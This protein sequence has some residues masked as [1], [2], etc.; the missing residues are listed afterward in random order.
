MSLV[1]YIILIISLFPNY[2]NGFYIMSYITLII[3]YIPELQE[4][5]LHIL[6]YHIDQKSVA[7]RFFE[8][9]PGGVGIQAYGPLKLIQAVRVSRLPVL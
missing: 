5:L 8:V 7:L 6:L 3:K 1:R 4:W 9:D 2:R